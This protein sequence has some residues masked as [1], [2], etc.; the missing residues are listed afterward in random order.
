MPSSPA[1]STHATQEVEDLLDQLRQMTRSPSKSGAK[2]T[3]RVEWSVDEESGEEVSRRF[4]SLHPVLTLFRRSR[5]EFVRDPVLDAGPRGFV[6]SRSPVGESR[7]HARRASVHM[8][9]A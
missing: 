2:R 8:Q 6:A 9:A 4:S 3:E 1:K 5:Q 7:D